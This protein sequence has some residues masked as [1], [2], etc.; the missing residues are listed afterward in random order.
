MIFLVVNDTG[1]VDAHNFEGNVV[2]FN[3]RPVHSFGGRLFFDWSGLGLLPGPGWVDS[4]SW[5]LV[6]AVG[7]Q[8]VLD[9]GYVSGF[10][11]EDVA[12]PL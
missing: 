1:L 9:F 4:V 10:V 5:F 3:D 7:R 12:H 2:I 6:I 8:K 11:P